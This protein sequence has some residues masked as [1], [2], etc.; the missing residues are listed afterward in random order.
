[1]AAAAASLARVINRLHLVIN[2]RCLL[3]QSVSS[4]EKWATDNYGHRCVPGK[5]KLEQSERAAQSKLSLGARHVRIRINFN[6]KRGAD[7]EIASV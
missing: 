7:D 4:R 2:T 3:F 1:M 5:L 6:E